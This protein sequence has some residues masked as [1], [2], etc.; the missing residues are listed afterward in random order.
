M[1]HRLNLPYS[2]EGESA[3]L[4]GLVGSKSG[5]SIVSSKTSKVNVPLSSS[6]EV[7]FWVFADGNILVTHFNPS[8][9]LVHQYP[10]LECF[11]D[12]WLTKRALESSIGAPHGIILANLK[13]HGMEENFIQHCAARGLPTSELVLL[14]QE[15]PA[16]DRILRERRFGNVA[17]LVIRVSR[18]EPLAA[19]LAIIEDQDTFSVPYGVFF[20][21]IGFKPDRQ[22]PLLPREQ[23]ERMYDLAPSLEF[24]VCCPSRWGEAAHI[25]PLA[26]ELKKAGVRQPLVMTDVPLFAQWRRHLEYWPTKPTHIHSAA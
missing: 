6:A 4:K 26:E 5:V 2:P 9:S 15:Y 18:I 13:T 16:A 21:P 3:F 22:V 24:I 10:S 11:L 20:D 8:L 25:D 1:V 12:A 14:D 19:V 17:P 23:V 7:D